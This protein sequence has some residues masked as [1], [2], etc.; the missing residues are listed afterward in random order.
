V[1]RG[2]EGGRGQ[3]II[4]SPIIDRPR[5]CDSSMGVKGPCVCMEWSGVEWRGV[6]GAVRCDAVWR[7][8]VEILFA[9]W[10][11]GE[12]CWAKGAGRRVLGAGCWVQG[13]G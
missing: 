12:G 13:A 6:S 7:R 2:E 1:G 9:P 11:L 5:C 10:V 3:L 4:D 8:G